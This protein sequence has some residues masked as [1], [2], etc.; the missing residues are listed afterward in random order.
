MWRQVGVQ[1]VCR[2][3]TSIRLAA[4]LHRR[5]R[6][7]TSRQ[8]GKTLARTPVTSSVPQT[9]ASLAYRRPRTC[10]RRHGIGNILFPINP[11]K[12]CTVSDV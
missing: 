2:N 10:R 3:R 4:R 5:N 9:W 7:E 11:R 1:S 12:H 6:Y 8:T